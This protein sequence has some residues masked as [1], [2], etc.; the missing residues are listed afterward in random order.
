MGSRGSFLSAFRFLLLN[1]LKF[2]MSMKQ[3]KEFEL[4]EE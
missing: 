2:L 1:F 3:G 4:Y